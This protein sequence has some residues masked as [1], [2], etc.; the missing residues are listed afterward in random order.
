MT[1]FD[2]EMIDPVII[3]KLIFA[4]VY[5]DCLLE[6]IIIE[7]CVKLAHMQLGGQNN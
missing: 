5:G 2:T 1:W 7:F 6:M 3:I 4:W